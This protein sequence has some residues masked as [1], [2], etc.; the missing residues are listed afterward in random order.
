M[1]A[2]RLG[3]TQHNDDA[4]D[5]RM[6]LLARL[7]HEAGCSWVPTLANVVDCECT[8]DAMLTDFATLSVSETGMANRLHTVMDCPNL[9][10]SG[11]YAA[12]E[13]TLHEADLS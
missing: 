12:I 11:C 7:N 2:K 3:L 4:L 6:N 10:C 8:A 5:V 9:H 1:N 13:L